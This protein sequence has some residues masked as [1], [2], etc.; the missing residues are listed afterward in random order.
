MPSVDVLLPTCNRPASLVMCLAGLAAQSLPTFH[1]LLADQSDPPALEQPVVQ[2]LLRMIEARG[3]TVESHHRLPSHGIAEQR[4]FLLERAG[5]DYVLFID[6][7]IFI[8]P[9]VLERLVELIR[10]EGCGFIGAFGAGLSFRQDVR[11]DQQ[12][13]EYWDG[14]VQPEALEPDGPGW[15]RWQ[16]HRAANLYHV[17]LKD[18]LLGGAAAGGEPPQVRLYKVAWAAACVLYDWRKALQVGGFSFWERLPRYH[19]GEEVL[20][21]NLLQ[22]R[23]GGCGMIPSGAYYAELPSTVLNEQGTVDGHALALLPEMVSRYAPPG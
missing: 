18:G 5:A 13:I 11:P 2:A 15:Q 21:Q 20:L 4:H 17:A 6:D 9:W 22:R 3:G 8:E 7:D 14:P 16:L 1:L 23:W 10:R 19:S 12:Q